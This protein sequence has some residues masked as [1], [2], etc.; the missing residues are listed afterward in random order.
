MLC[1]A[2]ARRT[3]SATVAADRR[4]IASV[5]MRMA[6]TLKLARLDGARRGKL[7]LLIGASRSLSADGD[8]DSDDSRSSGLLSATAAAA[9]ASTSCLGSSCSSAHCSSG[10]S[11]PLRALSSTGSPPRALIAASWPDS[12]G[13]AEIGGR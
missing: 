5:E 6:S 10:S 3:C 9:S 13:M 8:P 12:L 4:L 7:W 11:S 2:H 1:S